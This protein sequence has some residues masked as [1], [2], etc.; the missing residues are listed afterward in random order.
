MS[1]ISLYTNVFCDEDYNKIWSYLTSN[2][3]SYGHVSN[4]GSL[5][6]FWSMDFTND[7][8]FT[9]HLFNKIKCFIGNNYILERV[10]ANGQTHGLDG[11]FHQ[12]CLDEYGYT[13]LYYPSKEWKLDWGGS[14]VIVDG[15]EPKLVYPF[16]NT[17]V[18]FPGKLFH[19]GNAPSREF[20]DLRVSIAFKIRQLLDT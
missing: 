7:S 12:D 20:Y 2:N 6:R 5:K 16:P 19:C 11:E 18:I 1:K 4:R 9:E 8:F 10:Y 14:T 17:A 13:F 3:W 15:T